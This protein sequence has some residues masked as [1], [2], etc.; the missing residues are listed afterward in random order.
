MSGPKSLTFQVFNQKLNEIFQYQAEIQC[1]LTE[2]SKFR[3]VDQKRN[4]AFDCDDFI[5]S[6]KKKI[7]TLLASIRS[8]YKGT[9]SERRKVEKIIAKLRTF[10]TTQKKAKKEF[11]EKKDDYRSFLSYEKYCDTARESLNSYSKEVSEHL[12]E[13]FKTDSSENVEKAIS[14]INAVKPDFPITEFAFGFRNNAAA[15]KKNISNHIEEKEKEINTARLK[16]SNSLLENDRENAIHSSHLI[17]LS[18]FPGFKKSDKEIQLVIS[19]INVFISE[20]EDAGVKQ[21]CQQEFKKLMKSNVFRDVYFYKEFLED[22]KEQ[23]K[24][25]KW[26]DDIKDLLLEINMADAVSELHNEKKELISSILKLIDKEI[27]KAYEFEDIQTRTGLFLKNNQEKLEEAYIQKEKV[28]F[29]KQRL[30]SCME[31]MNY[32]VVDNMEVIDF[33]NQ[34]DFTLKIPDQ[35]NFL[36]LRFG[37]EDN[38][39]YNFLIPENRQDLSIEKTNSKLTDMEQACDDFKK[40]MEK[41]ED[42]GIRL[43]MKKEIHVSENALMQAPQKLRDRIRHFQNTRKQHKSLDRKKLYIDR[44]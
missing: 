7:S 9:L 15:M 8:E 2:L 44:S 17:D 23:K 3:V 22:L 38:I 36:N 28:R 29:V 42:F 39:L 4:I 1:L 40:V 43:D 35:S 27:L 32:E 14:R 13:S 34:S 31:D 11:L 12:N 10:I 21:K 37:E 25:R 24:I 6:N 41:L 19:K 26:K 20:I 18:V 33:E 16:L 5:K 30:I